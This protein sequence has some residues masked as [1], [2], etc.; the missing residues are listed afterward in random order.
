[1][2][3]LLWFIFA[4]LRAPRAQRMVVVYHFGTQELPA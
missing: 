4:Y 3:P 1:M 2:L